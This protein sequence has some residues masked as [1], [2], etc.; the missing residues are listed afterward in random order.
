MSFKNG[1]SL[2]KELAKARKAKKLTL[3]EVGNHTG[4]SSSYIF[5]IESGIRPNFNF[6]LLD[7]LLTL[8]EIDIESLKD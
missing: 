1:E 2:G 6:R 5:R 3:E 7:R 8:Y 4:V